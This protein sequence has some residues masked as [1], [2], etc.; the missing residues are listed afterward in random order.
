MKKPLWFF[1]L[2]YSIFGHISGSEAARE[3]D[4]DGEIR[5]RARPK[6]MAITGSPLKA[7]GDVPKS[8]SSFFEVGS[9]HH[10]LISREFFRYV[11]EK[12]EK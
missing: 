8:N 1:W 3:I 9:P 5:K 11:V 12:I 10:G 4:I 2:F 6:S 7:N